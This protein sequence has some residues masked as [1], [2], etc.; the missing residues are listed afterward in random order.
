MSP[1]PNEGRLP[2]RADLHKWQSSYFDAYFPG[3]SAIHRQVAQ[4]IAGEFNNLYGT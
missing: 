2:A 1:L 4:M 3:D